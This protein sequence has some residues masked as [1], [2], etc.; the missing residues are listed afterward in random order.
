[1]AVVVEAV[2]HLLAV[3]LAATLVEMAV[4]VMM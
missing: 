3:P 1:M 4:L 2:Q